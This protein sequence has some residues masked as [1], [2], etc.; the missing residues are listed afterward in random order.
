MSMIIAANKDNYVFFWGGIYSQWFKA[1]FTVQ[2][3]VYNCAE[4]YMMHQKALLFGDY[5]IAKQIM[6][7]KNPKTQKAL[8]RQVRGFDPAVWNARAKFFVKKGNEAK[9]T[10][11][12][13]LLRELV[14]T[15]D[16]T[17]V[18]ASPYDR[19]WGIGLNKYD[20]LRT[21]VENWKGTNWLGEV[22]TELRDELKHT[23]V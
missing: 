2:G 14:A 1:S 9:F 8:G 6:A 11:N 16:K 5:E 10:Q 12:E 13:D 20:A 7:T 3:T 19:I 22:L 15:G 18:E 23:Q 17:L 4:Q 21:P